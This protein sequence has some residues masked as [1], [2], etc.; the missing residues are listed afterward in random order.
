MVVPRAAQYL[1]DKDS[2]LATNKTQTFLPKLKSLIATLS[3]CLGIGI[4]GAWLRIL[5][6]RVN[7]VTSHVPLNYTGPLRVE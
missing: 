4:R 1:S 2:R 5:R 7:F 3:A 6:T